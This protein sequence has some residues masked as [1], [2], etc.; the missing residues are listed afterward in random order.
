MALS[1]GIYLFP[2]HVHFMMNLLMMKKMCTQTCLT[3]PTPVLASP[4]EFEALNQ[5]LAEVCTVCGQDRSDPIYPA[6]Q[7]KTRLAHF[8]HGCCMPMLHYRTR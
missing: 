4:L 8:V 3:H 6:N 1:P 5:P 7:R 2:V